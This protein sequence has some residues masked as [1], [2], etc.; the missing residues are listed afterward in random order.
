MAETGEHVKDRKNQKEENPPRPRC[1]DWMVVSGTNHYGKNR[2]SFKS[3]RPVNRMVPNPLFPGKEL[4]IA[5]V[6]T[7]ELNVRASPEEGSPTRTLVLDNVLHIP[8]AVCNGFCWGQYHTI[9]KGTISFGAVFQGTDGQGAALWFGQPFCGLHKLALAG[10]PQGESYLNPDGA[11][12]LS[13]YID[14][15]DLQNILPSG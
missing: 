12:M 1:R 9:H 11:H 8:V 6:G 14:E 13:L 4:Y 7:V 15:Q 2:A 5:G 3:Y 10:N